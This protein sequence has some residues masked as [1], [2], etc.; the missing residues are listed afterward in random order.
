MHSIVLSDNEVL[1]KDQYKLIKSTTRIKNSKGELKDY[2]SYSCSF[3][4]PF[5]EMFNFPKEIYFY[6]RM[7]RF[8]ITNEEPPDYYIW[9]KINL[10]TRKNQ[11][12]KSSKENED[13][14]WAKLMAVP[15]Q[16]MG[17]LDNLMTLHYCLHCNEKDYVTRNIGLL[18]VSLSR[19]DIK[20]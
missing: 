18:E 8:Y 3:P 10:Q 12:Q 4:Y 13:K 19:K 17:E 7:N 16:V 20:E 14:K 11:D 2:N 1:V 9:K 15:K 5:Y 6:E